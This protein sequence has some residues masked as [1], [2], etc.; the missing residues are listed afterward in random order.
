MVNLLGAVSAIP[1]TLY[2]GL[3]E[4]LAEK[5]FTRNGSGY[6]AVWRRAFPPS[7]WRNEGDEIHH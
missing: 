6:L 3:A 2:I 1:P 7:A 5:G 4:S